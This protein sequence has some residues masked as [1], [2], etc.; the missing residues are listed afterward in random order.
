MRSRSDRSKGELPL[1]GS[2]DI[3]YLL[4]HTD[5]SK[6]QSPEIAITCKL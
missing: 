2:V 6:S 5:S 4:R 1:F 3:E